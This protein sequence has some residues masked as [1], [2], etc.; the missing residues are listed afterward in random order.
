M[1]RY[2]S[3]VVERAIEDIYYCYDVKRAGDAIDPLE[4]AAR[5]GDGDACYLLSRCY[6]GPDYSWD[7]HPFVEDDD[8]VKRYI[9]QSIRLGSA[10][11]V[12]GAMRVGM[13]TDELEKEMPFGNL[14]QAWDVVYAKAEDG[15]LFCQN[16]IGNTYYW[17]DFMRIQNL[18]PESFSD[19][20][21]FLEF[22][23]ENKLKCIPWFEKAYYGG[24]GFAGRNLFSLYKS[25][26][27]G[28]VAPQPAKADEVGRHG[29]EKG[30]PEWLE[31]YGRYLLEGL[32]RGKE[33]LDYCY[34]AA[35]AGQY[36]AWYAIGN[37]YKDGRFAPKDLSKALESYEKGLADPK[38][39][40][41]Y[42][43]AGEMYYYGNGVPQNYAKAVE[44]FE[45]AHAHNNTWA[46]GLLG[47][48]YLKGNGCEKDPYRAKE[49]FLEVKSPTNIVNY[50]LAMIYAD[51]LGGE[52]VD[53]NKAVSH[54]Q[55]AP[56]YTPAKE[57]L[58][59]FKKDSSGNW[60]KKKEMTIP[61][62]KN[63]I[64]INR[65][66]KSFSSA[67]IALLFIGIA[68]FG[69]S[70]SITITSL[71]P[72]TSYDDLLDGAEVKVGTHVAGEVAFVLDCFAEES[73]YTVRSDGSRSGSE[74]SGNYYILPTA[75]GFIALK[76]N[77]SQVSKLD[78]LI[79]ETWDYLM[80]G[81]EPTTVIK[82]EG[83]VEKMESDVLRYYNKYMLNNG[84]TQEELDIM[85]EPLLIKYGNFAFMRILTLGGI[86][87]FLV[88][89][90]LVRREYKRL[91][92]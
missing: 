40:G 1:G 42:N 52:P 3:D 4:A 92:K 68:L 69:S 15:C 10:M 36:S 48:C 41:C 70:I 31:R 45:V 83:R 63:G 35:E 77:S 18:T 23:R 46:N 38:N 30:Y 33:G 75:D 49:L 89:I 17:G 61:I 59:R 78:K 8:K 74:N 58:T 88:A 71:I 60:R 43:A 79:D 19:N 24:M 90:F 84:Y 16:M 76:S 34:K 11:G 44:L 53:V 64:S 37:A 66:F 29:V 26:V 91:S 47:M 55:A 51:G 2:F 21:A 6:S 54:L 81:T 72:A 62:G 28:I 82:V 14:Q 67:S 65:I 7:Y 13:L 22:Y 12:L 87:A 56:N 20:T 80:Y 39:T 85:G 73:T 50:G 25:G 9:E 27:E 5:A 32:D 57:M 86:V